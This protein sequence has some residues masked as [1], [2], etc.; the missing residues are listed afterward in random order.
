MNDRRLVVLDSSVGVK[1]IKPES[2][3]EQARD[4]L[5]SHRNGEVRIV[6]PALFI[7]E[8]TGVAV[9][10]GGPALGKRVWDSLRRADLTVVALDDALASS[11]FEQCTNLNCSFYDALPPAV[12]ELLGATLYSADARA[13]DRF[14]GSVI[15][16]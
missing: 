7:H 1:W 5:L 6:V 15:L 3:R 9:R 2:G 11:A 16:G 8:V 12:A 4:L 13:H 14:P 10:H